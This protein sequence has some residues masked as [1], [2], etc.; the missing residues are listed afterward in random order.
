[1]IRGVNDLMFDFFESLEQQI[2]SFQTFIFMDFSHDQAWSVRAEFLMAL[3]Q[4]LPMTC[5]NC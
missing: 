2:S 3:A 1:M 5:V 4:P